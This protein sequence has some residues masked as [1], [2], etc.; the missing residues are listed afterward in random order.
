MFGIFDAKHVDADVDEIVKELETA[1]AEM[2]EALNGELDALEERKAALDVEVEEKR[3][4]AEA[5]ALGAGKKI[6]ERK[7][8]KKMTNLEVT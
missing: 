6:E 8:D 4:A 2:I 5:V 3:K 7:D 1:D